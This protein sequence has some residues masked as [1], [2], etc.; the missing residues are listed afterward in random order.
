MMYN[1]RVAR[2]VLFIVLRRYR[3]NTPFFILNTR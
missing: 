3:I 1:I 2:R